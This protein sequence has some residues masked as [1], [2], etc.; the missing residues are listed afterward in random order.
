MAN[1]SMRGVTLS[2]D[3]LSPFVAQTIGID[4]DALA[5]QAAERKEREAADKARDL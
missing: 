5:K 4:V 3:M 1:L 2:S